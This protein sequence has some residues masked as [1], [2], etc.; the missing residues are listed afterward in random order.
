MDIIHRLLKGTKHAVSIFGCS[1]LIIAIWRIT[2]KN[3][4]LQ[5][6]TSRWHRFFPLTPRLKVFFNFN[7]DYNPMKQA[8]NLAMI[9]SQTPII[10]NDFVQPV[11]SSTNNIADDHPSYVVGYRNV[12]IILYPAILLALCGFIYQL[13]I[14]LILSLFLDNIDFFLNL[15]K[16]STS[17]L[18]QKSS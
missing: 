18:K 4:K 7:S 16:T 2:I 3:Y 11:Q 8:H 15:L 5:L 10:L 17:H 13:I 1:F 12:S 9:K 6:W 14:I